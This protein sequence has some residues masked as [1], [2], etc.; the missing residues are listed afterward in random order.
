MILNIAH[1]GET[2]LCRENT[3]PAFQAAIE[4]GCHGVELDVR[5]S[6]DGIP[7]VV[8]DAT[9]SR[10]TDGVENGY[11]HDTDAKKLNEFGIPSLEDVLKWSK[12]RAQLFVELKHDTFVS[13]DLPKRVIHLL[14]E[15]KAEDFTTIISFS[16]PFINLSHKASKD[17]KKGLTF[18]PQDR[19]DAKQY[20]SKIEPL[21]LSW[22]VFHVSL[23]TPQIVS[24]VHEEDV[25]VA[26]WGIESNKDEIDHALGMGVDC[27]ITYIPK[28]VKKKISGV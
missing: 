14:K 27:L 19:Y 16:E 4:M 3:I 21:N 7:V 13:D 18:K 8:H 6:Q 25:K 22:I 9:L 23:I 10:I 17:F 1:R 28:E 26:I 20:L 11:I 24:A 5:L 15:K 12:K 2:S